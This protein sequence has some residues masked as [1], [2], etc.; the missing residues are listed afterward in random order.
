MAD[1]EEVKEWF[2]I[3]HGANGATSVT[4]SVQDGNLSVRWAVKTYAGKDYIKK[5]VAEA[6]R[7]AF[8]SLDELKKAIAEIGD[9]T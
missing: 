9:E 1:S 8:E 7:F 4:C 2:K 6:R 5:A 3:Q